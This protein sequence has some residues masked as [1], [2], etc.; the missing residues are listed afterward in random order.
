MVVVVVVIVLFEKL[1]LVVMCL[2]VHQILRLFASICQL[3]PI[4]HMFLYPIR[5][6]SKKSSIQ[7]ARISAKYRNTY[8]SSEKPS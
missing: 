5:T 8:K 7:D 2:Y 1:M 6:A 4:P 3:V